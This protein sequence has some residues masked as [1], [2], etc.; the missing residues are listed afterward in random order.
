MIVTSH[1]RED[2]AWLRKSKWPVTLVD[3]M[4]ARP[5]SLEAKWTLPNK[6]REASTYLKFIVESWEN[7]PE[8]VAFLHGHEDTWHHMYEKPIL[9]LIE[10]T[11]KNKR[12]FQSLNGVWAPRQ[13]EECTRFWHIV[14]PWLGPLP[15]DPAYFDAG[16][17]FIVGR[18]RIRSRP[19]K[20]YEE[21]LNFS[22]K[23]KN[24]TDFAVFMEG[25]W[26]YIWGEKWAMDEV[27]FETCDGSDVKIYN[28]YLKMEDLDIKIKHAPSIF[29]PE[30][31]RVFKLNSARWEYDEAMKRIIK[32]KDEIK[33][34]EE[35]LKSEGKSDD[36]V[37]AWFCRD[38]SNQ[39]IQLL[40]NAILMKKRVVEDFRENIILEKIR[41]LE[42][43]LDSA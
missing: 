13:S 32:F 14:E 31:E 6:G 8:W 15:E 23:T 7:L 4:G 12:T 41:R 16:A 34:E 35:Q 22:L 30:H 11:P 43:E 24:D 18:N 10:L 19:K 39:Y 2:L 5:T 17:Q 42:V 3:K 9:E 38:K 21:C 33:E 26:H 27:P 25:L 28:L 40:H 20:F 37:R 1:W 29:D 36:D